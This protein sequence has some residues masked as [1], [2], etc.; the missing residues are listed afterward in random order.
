MWTVKKVGLGVLALSVSME[1]LYR[2]LRRL[3]PERILNEVLF[4]PPEVTCVEHV[5][6]P[7]TAPACLCLLPHDVETSLSRLLRHVL[8]ASSSLD[9]CIFAFSNVNLSRAVLALHSRGVTIRVLTD[10]EYAAI[11]GSQ[12]GVLRKA[13]ICVRCDRSSV[14]MHHKFALVDGRRLITGSLN[15]TLTGVQSN[16]ENV[17]VTEEPDLVQP[18]VR[19][20][21][22]LWIDSEPK[23]HQDQ[24][25]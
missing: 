8:S 23:R 24:E 10:K 3:R 15:W 25:I 9:L 14:H 12:I 20:F 18:F 13:G 19:E 6:T 4:F 17:I 2:I 16:M 22:R 7:S 5:F 11:S 1:L 21:Q